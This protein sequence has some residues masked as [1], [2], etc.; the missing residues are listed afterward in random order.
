[1]NE[2]Y[3]KIK[4]LFDLAFQSHKRNNLLHAENL[5]KEIIEINPND[6]AT[7]NNL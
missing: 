2:K 7:L 6:V 1:M 4:K 5:Y 3:L